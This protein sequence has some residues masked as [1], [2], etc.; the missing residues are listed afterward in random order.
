M[1]EWVPCQRMDVFLCIK[2]ELTTEHD[3]YTS[4][5]ENSYKT[6]YKKGH[7]KGKPNPTL[8][9]HYSHDHF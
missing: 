1:L 3:T 8:T 4:F 9:A 7:W 5:S 2:G 6:L